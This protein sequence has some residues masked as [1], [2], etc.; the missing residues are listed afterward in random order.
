[1]ALAAMAVAQEKPSQNP[2]ALDIAGVG[3]ILDSIQYEHV[4]VPSKTDYT[5]SLERGKFEVHPEVWIS[6]SGK[7]IWITM[8]V[9]PISKGE[10]NNPA[11][12]A[13]L[14]A[15][16]AD[17]G[18]AQ[19]YTQN[20]GT[21]ANPDWRLGFGYPIDNR[22]VTDSVVKEALDAYLD[23]LVKEVPIW[24]PSGSG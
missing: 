19:F 13:K 7:K 14:L 18:P 24:Q 4:W 15:A 8:E 11:Y 10:L 21:G 2:D 5:V 17:V 9:R 6:T 23:D 22:A 20:F 12:L 1:M 16:N 3:K